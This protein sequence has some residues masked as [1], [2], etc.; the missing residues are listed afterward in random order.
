MY[1][2]KI[3]T[4]SIYLSIIIKKLFSLES[5][6]QDINLNICNLEHHTFYKKAN[7]TKIDQVTKREGFVINK[8]GW[9]MTNS[10]GSLRATCVI[11]A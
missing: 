9:Q 6:E 1:G 8:C 7:S 4:T 3:I 5:K 2:T 11:Y 10:N